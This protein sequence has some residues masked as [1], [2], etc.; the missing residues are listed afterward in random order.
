MEGNIE[1]EDAQRRKNED[2]A[3]DLHNL[4]E[5]KHSETKLKTFH[6]K[7]NLNSGVKAG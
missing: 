7:K 4:D 5:M 3:D 2:D 1:K 6:N